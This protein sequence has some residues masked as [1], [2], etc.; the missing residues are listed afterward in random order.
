MTPGVR[1]CKKGERREKGGASTADKQIS[2]DA[3]RMI[4]QKATVYDLLRLVEQE[5]DKAYTA[6]ELE[7]LFYGY[8]DRQKG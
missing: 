2:D 5:P 3:Y 1:S 8:I 7:K 4:I 6:K